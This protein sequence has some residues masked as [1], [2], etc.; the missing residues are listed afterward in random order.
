[1]NKVLI[2][3]SFPCLFHI[4]KTTKPFDVGNFEWASYFWHF[5]FSLEK[6][7]ASLII[8]TSS[9]SEKSSSFSIG[10]TAF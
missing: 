9:I 7:F 5:Q 10:I 6:L 8:I 1:M 2:E 4:L 3:T